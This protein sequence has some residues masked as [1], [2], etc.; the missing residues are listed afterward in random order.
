MPESLRER[1]LFHRFFEIAVLLKGINGIF[2]TFLGIIILFFSR[3]LVR[4]FL[5]FF[6]QG[7]LN[8]DPTNWVSNQILHIWN[9]ITPSSEFFMGV[10]FLVNGVVKMI[11]AYG[12]LRNDAWSYPA[13]TL[14]LSLFGV[15]EVFRFFHTH[16]L[17][18]AFLIL[19]D[20]ITVFLIAYEWIENPKARHSI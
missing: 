16:S 8:E 1:K 18:L 17:V 9:H 14:I 7:E 20:V 5:L 10:F 13:A 19:L 3:H 2:E 15:Y 12:L 6:V 4:N 11:L